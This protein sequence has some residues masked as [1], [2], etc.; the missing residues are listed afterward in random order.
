MKIFQELEAKKI[1]ISDFK[2]V[3]KHCN[4]ILGPKKQSADPES[5]S[6]SQG[7]LHQFVGTIKSDDLLRL[8]RMIFR[9]TKG[10][11]YQNNKDIP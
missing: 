2:N 4:E 5:F 6:I 1:Q 3:L 8:Q 10:N 7:L 9:A 11:V